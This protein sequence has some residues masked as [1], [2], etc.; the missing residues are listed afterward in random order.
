MEIPKRKI[1]VGKKTSYEYLRTCKACGSQD[2]V[3]H[4]SEYCKS[5]STLMQRTTWGIA[6]KHEPVPKQDEQRNQEMIRAFYRTKQPSVIDER[7][8]RPF[9][10][11]YF[12]NLMNTLMKKE[13][14]KTNRMLNKLR[15]EI[16]G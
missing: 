12:E 11:D 2:W 7:Q 3:Q 13:R 5:C 10:D 14:R 9:Q 16:F 1:K 8:E 6:Q 15:K 4:V